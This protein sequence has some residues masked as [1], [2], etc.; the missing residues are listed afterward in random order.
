M[1]VS[2]TKA[3][4]IPRI[5]RSCWSCLIKSWKHLSFYI[6]TVSQSGPKGVCVITQFPCLAGCSYELI[7][8]ELQ[9]THV[10]QYCQI[11]QFHGKTFYSCFSTSRLL[12]VS[13]QWRMSVTFF[14]LPDY[15]KKELKHG[16][17][18]FI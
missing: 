15:W 16:S 7:I 12:G 2:I 9:A 10:C 8:R 4:K 3:K 1:K 6:E 18:D 17:M 14:Y 11:S 5:L 13:K